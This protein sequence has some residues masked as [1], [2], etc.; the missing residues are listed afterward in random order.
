MTFL[1][2]SPGGRRPLWC[3]QL[4]DDL[5][6][7]GLLSHGLLSHGLDPWVFFDDEWKLELELDFE[8]SDILGVE[9]ELERTGKAGD[10]LLG[11]IVFI[12]TDDDDGFKFKAAELLPTLLAVSGFFVL[13]EQG[14]HGVFEFC[15]IFFG[16]DFDK[17]RIEL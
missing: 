11:K 17:P 7:H 10:G 8:D 16:A 4:L 6:S 9:K 5:L 1:R 2:Q 13:S 14:L 15:E 3:E 12:A